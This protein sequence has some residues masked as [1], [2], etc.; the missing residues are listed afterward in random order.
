MAWRID[1][2]QEYTKL[3][4][5]PHQ[6]ARQSLCSICIGEPGNKERLK[7]RMAKKQTRAIFKLN[8]IKQLSLTKFPHSSENCWLQR[9][10]YEENRKIDSKYVRIWLFK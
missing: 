7:E 8:F 1:N 4:K 2:E 6:P 9:I 10:I 5:F 3:K